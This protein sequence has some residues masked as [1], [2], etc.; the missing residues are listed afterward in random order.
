MAAACWRNAGMYKGVWDRLGYNALVYSRDY[1]NHWF[2]PPVERTILSFLGISPTK[3][4]RYPNGR[5]RATTKKN[6][7]CKHPASKTGNGLWCWRHTQTVAQPRSFQAMLSRYALLLRN[8]R[9]YKGMKGVDR[10]PFGD[11]SLRKQWKGWN[12]T[13]VCE[14]RWCDCRVWDQPRWW[15]RKT[16]RYDRPPVSDYGAVGYN[17]EAMDQRCIETRDKRRAPGFSVM[18]EPLYADAGMD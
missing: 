10:P 11:W 18:D 16:R 6:R 14:C 5:C 3:G 4:G 17:T 8:H 9:W 15:N 2:P 7:L 12:H 1:P 13:T